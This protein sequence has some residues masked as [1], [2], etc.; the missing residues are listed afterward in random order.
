M[1]SAPP[2]PPRRAVPAASP[3]PSSSEPAPKS[4]WKGKASAWGKV[5][6]AK[7]TILSDRVG[8]KVNGYSE[9]VR[10]LLLSYLCELQEDQGGLDAWLLLRRPRDVDRGLCEGGDAHDRARGSEVHPQTEVSGADFTVLIGVDGQRAL[11][12]NDSRFRRRDEQGS[13]DPQSLHG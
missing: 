9:A 13:E 7:G 6:V 12:A 5:A 3:T 2:P 8:V 1:S 10:G 4:G 11:L